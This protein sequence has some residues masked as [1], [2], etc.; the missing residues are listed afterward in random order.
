MRDNKDSVYRSIIRLFNDEMSEESPFSLHH[1]VQIGEKLT[2]TKVVY[3]LFSV[4]C[5]FPCVMDLVYFLIYLFFFG[6]P[7]I[8]YLGCIHIFC[9]P[10]GFSVVQI[11]TLPYLI[12]RYPGDIN[13][14]PCSR[15]VF[16]KETFSCFNSGSTL[17]KN[18]PSFLYFKSCGKSCIPSFG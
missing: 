18:L 14:V 3:H 10:D 1:L 11:G 8:S 9:H 17:L 5:A 4:Q 16:N 13:P 7:H 15:W 2:G 12:R 6:Y